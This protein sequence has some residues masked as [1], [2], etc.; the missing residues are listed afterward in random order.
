V[1]W[2]QKLY[3]TYDRCA[4]QP[5]FEKTPLMPVDHAEQQ[6]HIEITLN[7]SGKFRSAAVVEQ[8]TTFI[9]ATEKSAGRTS[10]TVAHGL[11]DKL[12][13]VAPDGRNSI[14]ST[15]SEKEDDD[16]EASQEE[17]VP[18]HA[19]YLNQLRDWV[20]AEPEPHVRSV[21]TYVESGSIVKDLL[22][23]GI[24]HAEYNG[25][26]L[27]R[28]PGPGAP[29]AI[30][31]VLTPNKG[32]RDQLA[33][34]VRWIVE[35]PTPDGDARLWLN[36]AVRTSWQRF[37]A[38]HAAKASLCMVTGEMLT[39]A[40]N[41]P[42]RLRH[43]KDGAKLISSND[44]D[45]FTY[46]GRFELAEHAYGI[47]SSTTQKAHNA[48]RWL[49]APERKQG[50]RTGDQVIVA[51]AVGGQPVPAVVAATDEIV[52]TEK[53]RYRGDAGQLFAKRLNSCIKGYEAKLPARSDIVVMAM[54]S[55]SPGR[56][57]VTFYRELERSEFLNRI[58]AWH[59]GGAWQQNLA[60]DRQFFGTPA[61]A[62]IARAAYGRQVKG[63]KT[64][65]LLVATVERL[66]PCIVDGRPFP[67]DLVQ[68][69]VRRT[70]SRS[71]L[72]RSKNGYEQEFEFCLGIACSVLKQSRPKE[73]YTMSLD[74]GRK[75]R[76][77]LYG[78]L[79]AV[80]ENIERFALDESGET[81]DTSASRYMQRF[82]DHPLQTWLVI[83]K[84]LKPYETRL[85]S[86]EATVG[87]LKRRQDLI[88]QI[89]DLFETDDFIKQAQLDGE[90][91][92]GY[93]C[94]RQKLYRKPVKPQATS[95]DEAIEGENDELTVK[96]D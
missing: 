93:Y 55:A 60:W 74:E 37:V 8:E 16:S 22:E 57:A 38:K 77:Y 67:R 59:E 13:Y 94:Q 47:G 20:A 4:G 2:I 6:V 19:L 1:T 18:P 58:K 76:S 44:K 90:F 48:L 12:K 40:F 33:A 32:E 29:P 85:R 3:E 88:G 17:Q 63:K 71:S 7:G 39:P 89:S 92:L 41:H 78:R 95:Q 62:D 84:N 50:Y 49:I 80:A 26:L 79:L 54:D 31:K 42:K 45:G 87:F 35:M 66:L 65:K 75:T 56:L 28:W 73:G 25:R 51:W 5:Q 70:T 53:E 10:G 61:P 14:S 72:M 81:R 9:P 30:F 36:T 27:K 96:Q 21:L 91:L 15:S 43:G 24:L 46:R 34:V 82:A 69:C 83:S 86:K 52:P 23:Q 11:A 68:S 64:S